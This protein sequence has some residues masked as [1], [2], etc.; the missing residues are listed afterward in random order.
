MEE[1]VEEGSISLEPSIASSEPESGGW[2]GSTLQLS[3]FHP[4]EMG[5]K[6]SSLEEGVMLS[7][8]SLSGIRMGKMLSLH[9]SCAFL[10]PGH[11]REY[12]RMS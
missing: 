12:R 4:V 1:L 7:S 8:P 3:S 9:R 2:Y 10:L 5:I 11:P 6:L